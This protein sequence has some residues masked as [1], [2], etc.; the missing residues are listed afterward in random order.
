MP[1]HNKVQNNYR[2]VVRY[3]DE[4]RRSHVE[5]CVGGFFSVLPFQRLLDIPLRVLIH[6]RGLEAFMREE[7]FVEGGGL[8]IGSRQRLVILP[9]IT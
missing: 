4:L 3:L 6:L 1:R 9:L 7:L 8:M 2:N 5:F